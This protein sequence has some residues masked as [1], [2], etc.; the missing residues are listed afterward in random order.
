[1]FGDAF[2]FLKLYR[3]LCNS[4]LSMNCEIIELGWDDYRIHILVCMTV[5]GAQ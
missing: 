1:M 3:A 2:F 5:V 4:G